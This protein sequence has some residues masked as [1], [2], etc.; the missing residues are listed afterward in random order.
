MTQLELFNATPRARNTD[1]DSSHEAAR[2]LE[3]SGRLGT[4]MARVFH[5]LRL[6]PGATSAELAHHS[7]VF[8]RYVAARRLSDLEV[9]GLVRKGN[10]RR[11]NASGRLA[12]TWWPLSE[13]ERHG[14]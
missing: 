13:E 11:C 2:L 3:E 9:H 14:Q 8:D 10:L 5:A 1:P 6:M 12:V 7:T 4:Q